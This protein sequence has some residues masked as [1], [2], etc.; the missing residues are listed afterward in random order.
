MSTMK[1]NFI[2]ILISNF[3]VSS[4][5]T[6]IMPFLSL[7]IETMGNFSESYVQKWA[8]LIFG[9]T[10]ISA[11]LM[12]PIWG[13][14]SDK[15]GYKPIMI[16][17]CFGIALSIFLMGHVQDVYQFF[18]LR[19]FMGI[20]TGF[21]PTSM[22]FISKHTPKNVAGKTLGTLQIG[23]VGGTLFGPIIG[24][25]LADAVGFSYTFI[26][27]SI[28]IS[29][30][31]FIIIIGIHEPKIDTKKKSSVFSRKNIIW[32]IFHHR[33]I[34]NTMLVTALIQI[35]NFS[36]QPL[37]S[38]YVSDLTTSE[39]VAFLSGL[40]FSAAGVGSLIF[41]RF[42]GRLAD[43]IGYEKVLATLLFI[44]VL[45]IIPQALVTSLWQL[46]LL[47]FFFGI[48]SG[49]LIPIT[50]ALIRREA[51]L[52]VQGEI[53]GYNQ[54]FRFLGNIIG[55]VFGGIISGIATISTVFYT[56][57]ILFFIASIIVFLIQRVPRQYFEDVLKSHQ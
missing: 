4:S 25:S 30:A 57:G 51:P 34:L 45:F 54:S 46:I 3:I 22:A 15:Y 11:F 33:L 42:F 17:N 53:M 14:I 16:I 26:L 47:R 38:L 6:M 27:T 24:G 56:T 21:I 28:T 8:G 29:L 12:S 23:S 49:G 50:T 55:P 13:R 31:A 19:L 52:E 39:Q 41:S 20:V 5:L 2:I 9:A 35:G 7:Y 37:L 32:A 40:T 18:F 1:R 36:I 44:T 10:F 43:Q 48:F